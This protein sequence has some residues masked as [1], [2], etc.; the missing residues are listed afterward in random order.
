MIDDCIQLNVE[1]RVIRACIDRFGRGVVL[2]RYRGQWVVWKVFRPKKAIIWNCTNGK[3][4]R[5]NREADAC[6]VEM[7]DKMLP[8]ISCGECG[9][10][11]DD[12][13]EGCD[14]CLSRKV[15]RPTTVVAG[16]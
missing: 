7:V 12:P 16:K 15:H 1:A 5:D 10:Y 14:V 13:D 3:Y 6:F 2:A 9:C 4:F 8:E 11:F